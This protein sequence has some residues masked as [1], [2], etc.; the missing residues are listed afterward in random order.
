MKNTALF[1][2]LLFSGLSYGQNSSSTARTPE[3]KIDYTQFVNPLIGTSKMGHVYPGATAPFGMVQ[4]S[5]QTN[6]EVMFKEDGSYNPKTYEYCAGYILNGGCS[7]DSFE[8]FRCWL[9]AHGKEHFYTAMENPDTLVVF[10]TPDVDDY[11]FEDFM[12][13]ASD[14]FEKKTGK[15][16]DDFIDYQSFQFTEGKYPKM[17]FN[18]E[19]E[20]IE[21]MKAICPKLMEKAWS[22]YS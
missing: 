1:I 3:A 14:A 22:Q 5:P 20:D 10:Y 12:Y 6:F 17:E 8:Y 9:I 16:I 2:S 19:E 15:D 18:W 21:S 13:V 11:H 7:D 4:L